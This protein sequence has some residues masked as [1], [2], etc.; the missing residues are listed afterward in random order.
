MNVLIIEDNG[1]L[2]RD[3]KEELSVEHEVFCAYNFPSAWYI[4]HKHKP[5]AIILDINLSPEGMT[6]EEINLFAPFIGISFIKKIREISDIPIILWSAYH[7]ST[8]KDKI[9]NYTN[10]YY[11]RK[12]VSC[13]KELSK[14]LRTINK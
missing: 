4:L 1:L 6:L 7:Y 12:G 3:A 8:I 2:L 11:V 14:L 5:D 10:I 13:F 9:E